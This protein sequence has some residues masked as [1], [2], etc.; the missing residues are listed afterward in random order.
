MIYD[1]IFGGN[2]V[3]LSYILTPI[4]GV[5]ALLC[6]FVGY[7]FNLPKFLNGL[8]GI[9]LI[10]SVYWSYQFSH[11][12]SPL[13]GIILFL[14]FSYL[15]RL[16]FWYIISKLIHFL[17]NSESFFHALNHKLTQRFSSSDSRAEFK[18]NKYR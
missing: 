2:M 5:C 7:I 15:I 18:K 16:W 10:L 17:S 1:P 6:K 3:A 11:L 13:F 8:I 4:F 14:F 9:L 12:T